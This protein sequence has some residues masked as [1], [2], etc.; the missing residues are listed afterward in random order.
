MMKGRIEGQNQK[1]F[2]QQNEAKQYEIDH[3]RNEINGL[4]SELSLEDDVEEKKAIKQQLKDLKLQH[5]KLFEEYRF[6]EKNHQIIQIKIKIKR[7][8]FPLA[9]NRSMA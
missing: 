4:R 7:S 5:N 1:V 2:D 8:I 3:V 6:V 9:S